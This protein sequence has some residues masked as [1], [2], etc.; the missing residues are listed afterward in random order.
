MKKMSFAVAMRDYFGFQP[1]TGLTEFMK[2]LKALNPADRLYFR[3]GL[4]TV[5]YE[6]V[7]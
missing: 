5:G 2:E 3:K 4:E 7:E 6:I 1:D